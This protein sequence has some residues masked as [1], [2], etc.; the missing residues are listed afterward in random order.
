[1]LDLNRAS[2]AQLLTLPGVNE[3][4]AYDLM[5]WRPYLSWEE[6]GAVPGV[7]PEDLDA[8]RSAGATAEAP[9]ARRWRLIS[10]EACSRGC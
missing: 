6:V 4:R 3:R 7:T 2:L 1:M 10:G 9:D 5:L 8:W